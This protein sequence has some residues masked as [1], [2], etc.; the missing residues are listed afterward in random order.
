MGLVT[1]QLKLIDPDKGDLFCSVDDNPARIY[2]ML[3]DTLF[4]IW[5]ANT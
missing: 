1:V 5:M 3:A 2:V 4:A